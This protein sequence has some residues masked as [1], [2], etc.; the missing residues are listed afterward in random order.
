MSGLWVGLY[1]VHCVQQK[2]LV[3]TLYLKNTKN[4][5][6]NIHQLWSTQEKKTNQ[7]YP[8][9]FNMKTIDIFHMGGFLKEGS[10]YFHKSS[11]LIGFFIINCPCMETPLYRSS[12]GQSPGHS[13]PKCIP[14]HQLT[15]AQ[16]SKS[17][18]APGSTACSFG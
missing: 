1:C 13:S 11:I 10:G 12:P 14:S 8:K 2:T 3:N 6:N 9:L 5:R 18:A 4:H 7:S 17:A 15:T 16:P